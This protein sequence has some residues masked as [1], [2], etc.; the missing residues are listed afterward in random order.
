MRPAR[1]FAIVV[2]AAI[3]MLVLQIPCPAWE[4]E[5]GGH[6]HWFYESYSQLDRQG[7]FGPY[8]V[9]RGTA[10]RAANLNFWNDGQFSN[11]LCTGS[12]AGW[13]YF[14]VEF[15]PK[16]KINEAIRFS[17]KYR[18]GAY[19]QP[20]GEYYHTQDAPGIDT[21]FTDGQW[22]MF[23]VTAVSPWGTLGLGKRPWSFGAGVQY[24][25]EAA[26]TT[27]SISLVAPFGPFDLGVAFYPYRFAGS[28]GIPVYS[29]YDPYDLPSYAT[30]N[31]NAV[32]GQ[33]FNRAD[34]SAGFSK[35]FLAFVTYYNGPVNVGVIGSVGAYHVG[36]E[37][38]LVDP[39]DPPLGQLSAMDSEFF[40]GSAFLKYANGRFFFNAEAAWVY[41]TDRW[42]ADPA[43]A[44][45]PPNPRYVEQWRSMVE[46]GANAGPARLSFLLARTPGPDRRN[47]AHID[48]QPA[49]FVRHPSFDRQFANFDV[50]RPY[51]YVF[52][53]NYGS[54]IGAHNLLG[55][56]Y[57]RDANFFGVKLQYAAASNLNVYGS[58]A[59]MERTSH[60]YSWGCIGPNAGAGAFLAAPDGNVS[61]SFNRYPGSPNIPDPALGY[62]I[63]VG[64]DW[65]LLEGWVVSP[66]IGF[67]Q[68]G[69][70]FSYACVDRSVPG[71]ENGGPGNFFGARPDRRIDPVIGGEICLTFQF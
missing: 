64:L 65:M 34:K 44:V 45:G 68:P 39:N 42:Q 35:D 7:F 30:V 70:W 41:W 52:S 46:F 58:F 56:G 18:L 26:T 12:G 5:M 67:W 11:A 28:S 22:T 9:D 50:F 14:Y 10:T 3:G 37:A 25:G 54:G 19:G 8:N 40:H 63:D 57:V 38:L 60:G 43:A 32:R 29:S 6:F 24:N 62:E 47:G 31:G 20:A 27:E 33:Y 13:S 17:G 36:P 59:Y 71:W 69:K 51:S 16:I 61:Y 53:Y 55:D 23:W 1:A 15:E 2:A 49:A 21:A 4:F 66:I 48:K